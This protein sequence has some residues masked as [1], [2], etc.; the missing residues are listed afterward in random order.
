[1]KIKCTKCGDTEEMSNFKF[2]KLRK[3]EEVETYV[4]SW[5]MN[6]I[7]KEELALEIIKKHEIGNYRS[8]TNEEQLEIEYKELK[9]MER[10]LRI[11]KAIIN[12]RKRIIAYKEKFGF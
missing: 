12:R 6:Q 5:C 7:R 9:T 3:N 11:P 4:C 2:E 10:N 8:R 1:M